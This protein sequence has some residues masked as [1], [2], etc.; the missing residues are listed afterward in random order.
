M[1]PQRTKPFHKSPMI[2]NAM[3]KDPEANCEKTSFGMGLLP[4]IEKPMSL[5]TKE[6]AR[7]KKPRIAT[8]IKPIAGPLTWSVT[9]T[10]GTGVL[11]MGGGGGTAP[12]VGAAP[13]GGAMNSGKSARVFHSVAPSARILVCALARP[14]AIHWRN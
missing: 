10:L 2:F 8:T 9:A 3:A 14:S 1:P 6:T 12:G 13:G 11:G 5:K 7:R 4:R